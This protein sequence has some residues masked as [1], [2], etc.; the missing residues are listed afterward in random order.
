[1][2]VPGDNVWQVQQI[3]DFRICPPLLFWGQS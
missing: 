2:V 1:M 3:V